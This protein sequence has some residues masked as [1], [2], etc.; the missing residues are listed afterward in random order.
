MVGDATVGLEI[1]PLTGDTPLEPNAPLEPC[2]A[3]SVL[4]ARRV[5]HCVIRTAVES[6][7]SERLRHEVSLLPVG[8]A[9]NKLTRE[10]AYSLGYN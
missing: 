8:V 6:D 4:E 1:R 7:L 10:L 9:G 3:P 5:K 2:Y